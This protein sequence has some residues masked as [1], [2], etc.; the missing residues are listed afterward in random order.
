[1]A[2][3]VLIYLTMP[4]TFYDRAP[5]V[6]VQEPIATEDKKVDTQELEHGSESSASDRTPAKRPIR[7]QLSL[8][9]GSFTEESVLKIF[10]RPAVMLALPP[11]LWA[12]VCMGLGVGIFVVLSTVVPTAFT[13]IYGFETWQLGQVW[14]AT[15]V[16]GLIGMPVGGNLSDW[17]ADALSKRNNGIR[18][19]EFRLPALL[20]TMI[21]YPASLVLF[22][23]AVEHKLHWMVP[24]V[25]IGICKP[26]FQLARLVFFPRN[27]TYDALPQTHSVCQPPVLSP[28][29]TP[30]TH[31]GPLLGRLSSLK[32][33]SNR[34]SRS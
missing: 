19:P 29:H 27:Q 4:E 5:Q 32:W 1:M 11:V 7:Q 6:H 3:T 12:T 31:T 22:G 25:A 13:E 2:V 20:P 26:P 18:E 21:S 33:G 15:I 30:L 17:V 34:L 28:W 16:G 23:L 10:Y 14:W 8:F 24:T 9:N